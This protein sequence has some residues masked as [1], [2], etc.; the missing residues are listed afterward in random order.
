MLASG[1]SGLVYRGWPFTA[2]LH[3]LSVGKDWA[4]YGPVSQGSFLCRN[5]GRDEV[6]ITLNLSA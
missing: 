3:C 6:S 4:P 5:E 1:D 2:I